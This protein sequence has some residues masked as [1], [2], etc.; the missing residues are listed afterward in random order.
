MMN[1]FDK[2]VRP[3]ALCLMATL[4]GCASWNTAQN[5]LIEIETIKP[6]LDDHL[7]I[8][9]DFEFPPDS[10]VLEELH[11]LSADVSQTLQ[12]KLKRTPV[13]INLYATK[14]DYQDSVR[15]PKGPSPLINRRAIFITTA[16]GSTVHSYWSDSIAVDLRHEVT[17]AYLNSTVPQLP[18]W[19]DEGLAEYFEVAPTENRI[20]HE[21]LQM[22]VKANAENRWQPNLERIAPLRLSEEMESIHYAEAWLWTH[23]LLHSTNKA[24]LT[25]YLQAKSRGEL[26]DP[27]ALKIRSEFDNAPQELLRHLDEISKN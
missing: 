13:H 24:V 21:H 6:P 20:N 2:C 1:G 18:L 17:H 23:F 12:L 3:M 15:S 11:T 10:L 7:I 8:H 25:D 27:L 22:L 14:K 9:A 26:V 4:L 19:L 5:T 16:A